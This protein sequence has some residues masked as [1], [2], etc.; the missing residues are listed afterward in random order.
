[1]SQY[2]AFHLGLHCFPKYL[3]RVSG[4][5]RIKCP[6]APRYIYHPFVLP[7]LVIVLYFFQIAIDVLKTPQ[8]VPSSFLVPTP[9]LTPSDMDSVHAVHVHFFENVANACG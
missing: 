1:M 5:P 6:P 3:F 8:H 4:L 2:A 7:Y 9:E